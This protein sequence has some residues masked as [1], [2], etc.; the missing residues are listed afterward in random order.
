MT[1]FIDLIS[2][3]ALLLALSILYSFLTRI[4]KHGEMPGRILAGILFGGVAV[5]GMMQPFNFAPGVIFD[6]RSMV[7]SMAGLFGGP[8]TAAI[9]ALIAG[10]YR[11]GLGGT[12]ALTG[13]GVIFTSAA[14]GSGYYYL[15]RK[16]PDVTKPTYLFAFGVI[17]HISMLLWMLTLPWPLAFE[18]I[19]K[20]SI[21]VML[22][23]PL[24]TLF[25]G[26][27]LA[28]QEGRNHAQEALRESEERYKLLVENQTDMVVKFNTKGELLFVSPSYCKTFDKTQDELLGER[29]IPLIHKEDKE[30]VAKTLDKV[31]RPPYTGYVEERAMTKDGWRWQS[32]ANT[33]VLD[34][35]NEVESIVA[36]GRD[37]NKQ[38]QAEKALVESEKKHREMMANISDVIGILDMDGTIKYKSPNIRKWFGWRPEDLVGTDGWETVHPDDLDRV[39]TEFFTLLKKGN[40]TT[41]VEYRYKCKDGSYKMI[42]LTAANLVKD[43]IVSGILMN[44]HDIT[45]RKRAE[46]ALKERESLFSQ[47]FEQSTTS[48]C[49]YNPDGTVNRINDE[50]CKMFGVEEKVIINAGYNLFKDQAAI[51]AGIIPFLKDIFEE[52]KTKHWE[53]KFDI[54]IA[55]AST[56]TPT[57][58][59]GK[60]FI[61]VFGYPVLNREGNLEYVVLQ[62]YDITKRMQSQAAL[63]ESEDKFRS[64]AEQS[65][66]GIYLISGDVFKYVNPKFAEMFG[67]SVDECLDNMHFPQLVHPE[68]LATVEKQVGRRLSEKTKSVRYSF[69][70]IKKSGETIHVE[71]FGSS[72]V[73][74]G[75]I[76]ATGT[77]MD[78]SDRINAEKALKTSE[79][80]LKEAQSAAKIGN[81]EYDISDG[82]VWGSEQA[83][84][85]YNIERTSPYLP[86]DR[87]EAC[88]SDAPRVH[89]ALVD[90][91]EKNKPYDIKFWIRQEVSGQAVLSHS[92]AALVYENGVPIK[93]KGI[94]QD[95]TEQHK[96]E[97]ERKHLEDQLQQA[98]KMEAIGT[99]AGGIAHDFNNLLMAIQ[100]RASIML[101]NKETSH[102]DF[103]HLKGIED[104]IESAADLTRQLLGFARGGKYEVKTIDI[105]EL[106]KKQ[107]RM[108]GRTRKEISIHGKYEENLWSVEVDRGQ[109]EQV[110]LNLYVNAWQAMPGGGD[111]Y[112]ETENVTL[113]ETDVK[114]F[115]IEPGE[116][117]KLSVTDTG[118][119]M[120]KATRERIFEPF[121]TTKEMGRGTGL[122]LAS[123]YGIIKN[124]G[125]FINVNSEKGHGTTFNVYLPASEKEVIHEQ[126]SMGNTLRG[127]ET[128]LFV[129]DEDMVIEVAEDLFERLG[130]KVMTAGSGKEAIET[131]EKNQAQVDIVLLD[132][133]MPDM[134]GSDT[135][136]RLKEI[137]PDIKVL[138]SSGYSIIGQA[139]EIMD[140]GC[141][142]FI[143]KPFKMK[144]L[145]Q[146]LREIL[147][148]K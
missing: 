91:I 64:F 120:D 15:R 44:Y 146:K 32:W 144:E 35:E 38:K 51:D 88:I 6:G 86:L 141:N 29:F 30:A 54:D 39:Q 23:F 28:D 90:L 138:L 113:G 102:P 129:D 50:F 24:A 46:E 79:K 73:L 147:D 145:S 108:F 65:L 11:L 71:I 123:A 122:G 134:S 92:M 84:R 22:I 125:G 139:T 136:D 130:Y 107:N 10:C 89:Q 137:D 27:L 19:N 75:K 126:K 52:R 111:L 94:I 8:V 131:Y 105:N 16:N 36:V 121:F 20:I 1:I 93:V 127:T 17:V 25:L 2:N 140:R 70:G 69:R 61:E 119:G 96:A 132:M 37:I 82:K 14:L 115:S 104:N 63:K 68:D 78:I 74:K 59:T 106:I 13:F 124:H 99:L 26:T 18:V 31:H 21:P 9:S 45:E 33:A 5:A 57:W 87:V 135:Y 103:R 7:V 109:I 77:I 98:Q 62:H 72:M 40:S 53:M 112:L 85:V 118:V 133:I 4:W 43:S 55:S 47:M 143:Q 60:I 12:G 128:V 148:E 80:R 42:E 56:G 117:V 66:V 83:F 114:P 76:V 142:G 116:Y 48:M 41:T 58:R 81:W 101:M 97:K 34:E 95:V 3:M 100:G 110:L 49:L 67:Y